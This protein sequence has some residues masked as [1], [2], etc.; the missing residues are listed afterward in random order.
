MSDSTEKLIEE[1]ELLKQTVY[2]LHKE[3]ITHRQHVTQRTA[4]ELTG[5]TTIPD[6]DA[7]NTEQLDG[8]TILVVETQDGT[9][10]AYLSELLAELPTL[11]P[12]DIPDLP[13]SKITSEIFNADRIPDIPVEKVPRAVNSS[14]PDSGFGG[15]R[16][17]ESNDDFYLFVS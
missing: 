11:K 5:Y 14:S 15:F 7:A 17:T 13:A 16:Y 10:R 8:G 3:V 2:N 9:K 6:L 1:V 12:E 4:K